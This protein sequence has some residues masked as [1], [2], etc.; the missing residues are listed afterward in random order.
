MTKRSL[1]SALAVAAFAASATPAAHAAA[2]TKIGFDA[3]AANTYVTDQYLN[4]DGVQF[5]PPSKW[6]ITDGILGGPDYIDDS[7]TSTPYGIDNGINGRAVGFN[8]GN[9][10]STTAVTTIHFTTFRRAASFVLR[11]ATGLH[12]T[13]RIRTF[14]KGKV[15]SD[16]RTLALPKGQNVP[17]SF[18]RANADI[19]NVVIDGGGGGGIGPLLLDDVTAPV[20]DVA[21][22]AA[23]ELGDPKPLEVAEGGTAKSTLP[24]V[25]YNGSTG[26]IGLSVS[27]LPAGIAAVSAEPNPVTGNQPAQLAVSARP[28]ATGKRTLTVTSANAGAAG[29]FL[30][31]SVKQDVNLITALE[32]G[33][34]QAGVVGGCGTGEAKPY[35]SVRGGYRGKVD[36]H[37]EK[38]S[39]PVMVSNADSSFQSLGDG[40]YQGFADLT[41]A[42]NDG[43]KESVLEA[44][45]TPQNATPVKA[46]IRV[47]GYFVSMGQVKSSWGKVPE[48]NPGF[49]SRSIGFG[50]GGDRV[51][52]SGLFPS[53]CIPRFEDGAGRRMDV[54]DIEDGTYENPGHVTLK[55][56]KDPVSGFITAKGANDVV[57]DRSVPGLQLTGFR[58]GPGLRNPNSGS[59]AGST[60]YTWDNFVRTFG[61]DDAEICYAVGCGRDPVAVQFWKKYRGDLQDNKGLCFGYSTMALMFD[62]GMP[63]SSYEKSARRAWDITNFADGQ[64]VKEDV[65]RWQMSQKDV[66]WQDYR[67]DVVKNKT[68]DQFRAQLLDLLKNQEAVTL[69]LKQGDE[70]HAVDAYDLRDL[71]DGG[72]EILTYNPNYPYMSNEETDLN[73]LNAAVKNNVIT[74]RGGVWTGGST[75]ADGS[76][77]SGGMDSIGAFDHLPPS[78]AELA[79][80]FSL[81]G[82]ARAIG[83]ASASPAPQIGSITAGGVEA[84]NADGTSKPG[85]GVDAQTT[86]G[87]GDPVDYRL[88]PGKSYT[89]TMKGGAGGYS[90]SLLSKDLATTI[91]SRGRNSDRI[92]LVPG[93]AQAGLKGT[94][95]ASAATLELAARKGKITRTASAAF[96]AGRGTADTIGFTADRNALTV[97]HTG[98]PTAVA[99]T[100]GSIGQG[101]PGGVTTTAIKVGGGERLELKPGSWS[102][103]AAGVGFTVRNAKG[104]VLRR[105]RARLQ[106]A[107]TVALG[108][109]LTA[110]VGPGGKVT[111]AG[112]IARAGTAPLLAITAEALKGGKVVKKATVLKRS[113]KAGT[114]SVPVT[115]K[116]LPKG[117]RVRVS[118]ALVDEGAAM[119]TARRTA[120]AR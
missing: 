26:P 11:S 47:F 3:I 22:P 84:L 104:K 20:D 103:P 2:P 62:R 38:L 39:G 65:V 44:T 79:G 92:T 71:P 29:E 48:F 61:D 32:A 34:S 40:S 1:I 36:V 4:S 99:V 88:T 21:P 101:I 37:I 89:L 45:F 111:V 13:V 119:A 10:T 112:R 50:N 54:I 18:T 113:V 42:R 64:P 90:Q 59:G 41:L 17:Y 58:N 75:K 15:K 6:G 30:G 66:D 43:G 100:L 51:T 96:T 67:D 74:V 94:G 14:T 114:F 82:V 16:D 55:L 83:E 7:C 69:R 19:T 108:A 95:P 86:D 9:E 60:F 117:A 93:Q 109:K 5:G 53:G 115:L 52:I 56:P 87:G 25:R 23:F 107:K 57:L 76:W 118:A 97:A 72:F 63:A 81:A 73:V 80:N 116:G 27:A 12:K 77:W 33:N 46:R 28:Y 78:D 70:G 49:G 98:A 102:N 105:G 24:V 35:V 68:Q 106:A 31:G 91:T 110:K 85:T 8:C 120:M